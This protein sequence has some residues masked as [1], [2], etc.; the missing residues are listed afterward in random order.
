MSNQPDLGIEVPAD[1]DRS[2]VKDES[3]PFF[4]FATW[5][6]GII[7]MAVLVYVILWQ[8]YFVATKTNPTLEDL[9]GSFSR[10]GL[11]VD[12]VRDLPLRSGARTAKQV[13]IDGHPINFYHFAVNADREQ[14]RLLDEVERTG[15]LK[16]DGRDVPAK[17]H[18]PFVM[19]NWE[20]APR[21]E[22]IYRFYLG[23]GGFGTRTRL[24]ETRDA[25][26]AETDQ[27][28]AESQDIDTKLK[29]EA[30]KLFKAEPAEEPKA[31]DKGEEADPF[32]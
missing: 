2:K 6:I 9:I 11:S 5:A 1:F 21:R 12:S 14:Q 28:E 24:R 29:T 10:G 3:A 8:N 20:G 4:R 15:T 30:D 32:E 25:L 31:T 7:L 26:R 22:T 13:V 27:A 23:F 18:G 17:V 19:T 16:V